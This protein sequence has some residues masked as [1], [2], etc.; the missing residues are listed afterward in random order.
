MIK[1][2]PPSI[3][4]HKTSEYLTITIM[5][6][7]VISFGVP[8]IFSQSRNS[9]IDLS[10]IL[11]DVPLYYLWMTIFNNFPLR[12][13]LVRDICPRRLFGDNNNVLVFSS[14]FTLIFSIGPPFHWSR[15]PPLLR[16]TCSWATLFFSISFFLFLHIQTNNLSL[17]I[18]R[19]RLSAGYNHQCCSHNS[20]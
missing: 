15:H 8:P 10:W 1:G 2:E 5:T 13:P 12:H 6:K 14:A 17:S 16:R 4:I 20:R 7:G 18:L 19:R 11:V 9:I 3:I